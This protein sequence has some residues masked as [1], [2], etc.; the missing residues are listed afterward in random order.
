[1]TLTSTVNLT[2]DP[3]AI[4]GMRHTSSRPRSFEEGLPV[5]VTT[6]TSDGSVS[7]TIALR[8]SPGP[9]F[10]TVWTLALV[11]RRGCA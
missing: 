1:M 9:L 6:V 2:D 3:D 5:A 8:A 10:V 4:V 11:R 7:P